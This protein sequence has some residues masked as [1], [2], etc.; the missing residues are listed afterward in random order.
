VRRL[1]EIFR[2]LLGD[3]EHRSQWSVAMALFRQNVTSSLLVLFLGVLLG[4]V[5]IV[6][7]VVNFFALGF[8]AAPGFA[9]A[10]FPGYPGSIG[11]FILAVAPHGIFELPALLLA[12]A[13]G[14]RLG[15]L[16]LL[17]QASRR[18]GAVLKA[19]LLDA[20]L[21]APVVV[22]L[23]AIAALIEAFVTSRL[24]S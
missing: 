1:G 9:P 22:I 15:W 4:L 3:I 12:S 6:S 19:S 16:W 21:I 17:P 10:L 24:L 8:L 23:L 2:N 14:L 20:A 7:I 5:P 13:F 18:R 11:V